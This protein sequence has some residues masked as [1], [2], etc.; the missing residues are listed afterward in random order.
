MRRIEHTRR[1]PRRRSH[2]VGRRFGLDEGGSPDEGHREASDESVEVDVAL[3]VIGIAGVAQG[4]PKG[5]DRLQVRVDMTPAVRVESG[6]LDGCVA[7][8]AASA[9]EPPVALRDCGVSMSTAPIH[10]SSRRNDARGVV[11]AVNA[12]R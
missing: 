8:E 10:A 12:W 6:P 3:D 7:H 11:A 1:H 9:P 4:M 2:L 5:P